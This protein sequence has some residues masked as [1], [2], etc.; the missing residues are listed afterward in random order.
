MSAYLDITF[1]T[2]FINIV[3]VVTNTNEKATKI[4][5]FN[6][7]GN[8]TPLY[9]ENFTIDVSNTTIVVKIK[10]KISEFFLVRFKVE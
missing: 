6:W 9:E 5:K 1:L 2:E 3:L 10:M 7:I 8:S 4:A